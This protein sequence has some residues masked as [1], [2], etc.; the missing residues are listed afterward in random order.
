MLITKNFNSTGKD[1]LLLEDQLKFTEMF[2]SKSG[3]VKSKLSRRV[4]S[5]RSILHCM[6]PSKWTCWSSNWS[7]ESCKI[8]LDDCFPWS[9]WCIVSSCSWSIL[10]F[11]AS[12][13]QKF[14]D[15]VQVPSLQSHPPSSPTCSTLMA[16][17][18]SCWPTQKPSLSSHL[19]SPDCTSLR[20]MTKGA[21]YP[22]TSVGHAFFLPPFSSPLFPPPAHC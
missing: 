18:S 19:P 4:W 17:T 5:R 8:L 13:G 3:E 21:S 20:C 2:A 7:Q 1:L 14:V 9:C 22:G 6:V 11:P 12:W 15:M 10:W 16:P